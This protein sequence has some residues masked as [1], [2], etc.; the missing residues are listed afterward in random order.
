MA[1]V[2]E[3]RTVRATY[4][5]RA[6]AE[7]AAEGARK[8]GF[9]PS[10]DSETDERAVLRA[11]MRDE[12]ESTVA[13]PGNVG[14]FTKSMTRGILAWVPMG[15]LAGAV[16]GALLA[17]APWGGWLSLGLRLVLGVAIG[18]FAGATA[19]FV[20]GGFVRSRRDR[21]GQIL[22]A[23]AGSIVSVRTTSPDEARRARELLEA[24]DP[25]RIDEAAEGSPVGPSSKEKTKPVSGD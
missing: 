12:V 1:Q 24:G 16:L 22:D 17:L 21:E 5:S 23:E 19:G 18:G 9:R 25:M 4:R 3:T 2:Q 11:E 7:R 6:A 8:R 15:A 14:P 13:G 20:A 10:L